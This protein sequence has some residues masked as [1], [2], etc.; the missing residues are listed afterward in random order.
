M[1]GWGWENGDITSHKWMYNAQGEAALSCL[2]SHSPD[3]CL[4]A[5]TVSLQTHLRHACLACWPL[6]RTTIPC[7]QILL[8]VSQCKN[9]SSL[10]H[11]RHCFPFFKALFLYIKHQQNFFNLG[12]YSK[13]ATVPASLNCLNRLPLSN[14]SYH[15]P[16]CPDTPKKK[17]STILHHTIPS[18]PGA[19][20][21]Y[22][23]T[24][25]ICW[26]PYLPGKFNKLQKN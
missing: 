5:S 8:I 13:M 9:C 14:L 25:I 6:L 7:P 15:S 17:V 26:I 23:R 10:Y 1:H 12:T 2:L 11:N 18:H 21:K 16:N 4:S 20:G 22:N 3:G 19:L 24:N